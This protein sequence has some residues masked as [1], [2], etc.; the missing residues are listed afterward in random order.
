MLSVIFIRE[1]N[2]LEGHVLVL[3]AAV[4]VFT[5]ASLTYT[6]IRVN[7]DNSIMRDIRCVL[8]SANCLSNDTS[9]SFNPS[10]RTTIRRFRTS[11]NLATSNI[12][13]SRAVRT[14]SRT[15]N[16]PVPRRSSS[17]RNCRHHLIVRTATCATT[18]NNNSNCATANRCLRHNVITISPSIVPLNSRL[19]VRNCNCTMTTSANKTVINS[20]V[21]L[22]VSSA[23]R[24]LSFNHHSIIICMLNWCR[25]LSGENIFVKLPLFFHPILYCPWGSVV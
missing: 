13:N 8:R 12:I 7:V 2:F 22:T 19:C 14:L 15:D 10:A 23:D 24:T 11:R 17:A 9:N 25:L 4:Y 5:F 16:H 3:V 1:N 20:H 21:S 18:S 6:D